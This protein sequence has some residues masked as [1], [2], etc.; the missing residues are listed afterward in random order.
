MFFRLRNWQ[1]GGAVFLGILILAICGVATAPLKGL[2]PP[3]EDDPDLEVEGLEVEDLEEPQDWGTWAVILMDEILNAPNPAARDHLLR[4][5][6]AAGARIIPHLNKALADDRTAEFAAQLLAFYGNDRALSILQKLEMDSRDLALRRFF[7]GALGEFNT[8]NSR[9]KLLQVVSQAD[10]EQDVTVTETAI[11]ALTVASDPAVAGR[12]K[13][14]SSGIGSILIQDELLSA[15]EVMYIRAEYLERARKEFPDG[16]SVQQAVEGYF[17][18]AGIG[19]GT[20]GRGP[21]GTRPGSELPPVKLHIENLTFSPNQLR[22]LARVRL[23]DPEGSASYD[24]VLQQRLGSW[25]A[26]SVWTVS[27]DRNRRNF[28]VP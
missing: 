17:V 21:E 9:E 2:G 12:L 25:E 14:L 20:T 16:F 7:Y 3:Q 5:G 4:S 28:Q 1:R 22:V 27:V 13:E 18:G 8:P 6:F 26:A 11:L 19:I 24:L 10:S 15:V 23:E